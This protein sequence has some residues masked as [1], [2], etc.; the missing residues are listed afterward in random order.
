MPVIFTTLTLYLMSF[1][2]RPA[3]WKSPIGTVES[4]R[5][6]NQLKQNKYRSLLGTPFGKICIAGNTGSSVP[7]GLRGGP[8]SAEALG[9]FQPVPTGRKTLPINEP[10]VLWLALSTPIAILELET[11]ATNPDYANSTKPIPV[12]KILIDHTAP[13]FFR[14]GFGGIS[15]LFRTAD[16]VLRVKSL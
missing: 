9:Y 5:H 16:L 12:R 14:L 13:V 2:I 10:L 8:P 3:R 6:S 11:R 15:A 1:H 7:T 4:G